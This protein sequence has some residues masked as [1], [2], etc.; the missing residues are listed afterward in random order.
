MLQFIYGH[1]LLRYFFY[2]VFFL[3]FCLCDMP[4]GVCV[5]MF[6]CVWV[7]GDAHRCGIPRLMSFT[8]FTKAGSLRQMQSLPVWL[9]L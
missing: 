6:V 1:L 5:H 2:I 3:N 9:V 8:L 4:I 7:S